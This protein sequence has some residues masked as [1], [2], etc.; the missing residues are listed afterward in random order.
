MIE[1][2]QNRELG[3]IGGIEEV[4][5]REAMAEVCRSFFDLFG[6]SMRI[7]GGKSS[8]LADAQIEREVCR[9]VNTTANGRAACV[10]TVNE[11]RRIEPTDGVVTH[12][13]FTGAVYR[14]APITYSGRVLG[15]IILGPYLPAELAEVPRS[16]LNVDPKIDP[17]HALTVLD[18]MPRVRRETS[19]RILEHLRRVIDLLLFGGHKVQLTSEMHLL[20]VRES[21]REMAQKNASL[22]K[23]YEDLQQLDQ[24]KS[25]FLA[26]VSHEL[27]TPLTSIIGYS[28]MLEAGLAGAMNEEQREYVSTI[29]RRGELLLQLISN[30]LDVNKM[31]KGRIKLT[32]AP[33]S[34]VELLQ[35]IA[36]TV[37]PMIDKKKISVELDVPPNGVAPFRADVFRMRQVISNLLDNAIKFTPQGGKVTLSLREL[38]SDDGRAAGSV[39]AVLFADPRREVQFDIRDTGPGIADSEHEKIFDAFYQVDG[40]STRQHG[41]AGIGLS[42]VRKIVEAHGGEITVKSKIGEGTTFTVVIPEAPGA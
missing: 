9:Y 19:D 16:L 2:S 10:A 39:G 7:I 27:R 13:C 41:G 30:L 28:E 36:T 8:M 4:L 22:Q 11:A 18:E 33:F 26:T 32:V 40:S 38:M 29:H 24:L 34:P 15:R 37:K 3:D 25:D 31:E 1:R 20:S 35:E 42:I 5:D 14:I 23:A 12:Q 21:F 6:L 17:K